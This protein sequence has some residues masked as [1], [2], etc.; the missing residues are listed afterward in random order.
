M[1][2]MLGID[3]L[4]ERIGI[5]PIFAWD[6]FAIWESNVAY[7][8]DDEGMSEEEAQEAANNTDLDFE[9]EC[10][11]ECVNEWLENQ[12]ATHFL[13][14]ARGLGW[15]NQSGYKIIA[16]EKAEEFIKALV[17]FDC[18][19]TLRCFE[20]D[21]SLLTASVYHH[22]SPT[23]E[24]R[25]VFDFEQFTKEAV[26]QFSLQELQKFLSGWLA[27][28]EDSYYYLCDLEEITD[29]LDGK[30]RRNFTKEDFAA[31][32]WEMY[33]EETLS[34]SETV[35]IEKTIKYYINQ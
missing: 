26:N 10:F 9:W 6:T 7:Y 21:K 20:S 28:N 8:R 17:G 25:E 33:K 12:T 30:A 4:R 19:Y 29:F 16:T 32:I 31:L 18:E 2:E 34:E 13:I 11:T 24:S 5:H 15:R 3:T 27:A 14:T 23:G 1:T 22:D 35:K